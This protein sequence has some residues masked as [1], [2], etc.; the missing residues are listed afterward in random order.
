MA[1]V[2]TAFLVLPEFHLCFYNSIGTQNMFSITLIISKPHKGWNVGMCKLLHFLPGVFSF[3]VVKLFT[4]FNP[5]LASTYTTILACIYYVQFVVKCT[6]DERH[7]IQLNLLTCAIFSF[8]LLLQSV[9]VFLAVMILMQY[10]MTCTGRPG[11]CNMSCFGLLC[12]GIPTTG[13]S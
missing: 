10:F 9:H 12:T 2:P 7:L 11:M 4:Y 1:R 5:A 8:H 6:I 13:E 3:H